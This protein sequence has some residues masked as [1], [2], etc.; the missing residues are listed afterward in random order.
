MGKTRTALDTQLREEAIQNLLNVLS[1]SEPIKVG[2]S[3]IAIP[4]ID[5][6]KNE[7]WVEISVKV[8]KGERLEKGYAGYDGFGLAEEYQNSLVEKAE[9]AKLALEKKNK[10]I[11]R[12]AKAKAVKEG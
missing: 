6:E 3:T 7:T 10:D 5:E 9:K 12:K 4:V 2:N 11:A 1:D 8:P